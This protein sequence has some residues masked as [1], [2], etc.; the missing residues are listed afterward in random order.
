MRFAQPRPAEYAI[1]FLDFGVTCSSGNELMF[2][3]KETVPTAQRDRRHRNSASRA[4][5]WSLAALTLSCASARN[6][7]PQW[8]AAKASRPDGEGIYER[9]CSS[10][11]GK[12]GEGSRGV[13][14]LVGDHSLPLNGPRRNSF[15]TARD[16]QDYVAKRMPLPPSRVGSLTVEEYWSVVDF[17]LHARGVNMPAQR[18][19]ESN[20][21]DVRIN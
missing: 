15:R 17:I 12:Q 3:R 21:A 20:A 2:S 9:A 13:P 10:C 8:A 7:A 6:V 14:E 16:L 1:R 11:H 5:F 18:L 4:W 19:G